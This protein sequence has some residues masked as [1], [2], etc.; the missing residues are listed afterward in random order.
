[1]THYL[2]K[3]TFME[4]KD[5]FPYYG[6]IPLI[7]ANAFLIFCATCLLIFAN[8]FG[9]PPVD[10]YKKIWPYHKYLPGFFIGSLIFLITLMILSAISGWIWRKSWYRTALTLF[11]IL[12]LLWMQLFLIRFWFM[13][14]QLFSIVMLLFLLIE[15]FVVFELYPTCWKKNIV[16]PVLALVALNIWIFLSY[17]AWIDKFLGQ[18]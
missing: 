4:K 8:T 10:V 15:M 6:A 2:E 7:I 18:K 17:P 12:N 14:G 13:G 3:E 11:S 5:E 16:L 1:V 9:D